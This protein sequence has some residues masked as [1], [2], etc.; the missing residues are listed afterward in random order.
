MGGEQ[1]ETKIGSGKGVPRVFVEL[2]DWQ[3]SGDSSFRVGPFLNRVHE[4]EGECQFLVGVPCV[5][6]V[7]FTLDLFFLQGNRASSEIF[8]TLQKKPLI[9]EIQSIVQ[10]L[11]LLPSSSHNNSCYV[12]SR[13]RKVPFLNL[14]IVPEALRGEPIRVQEC[15][16]GIFG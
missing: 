4:Y 11:N 1:G 5:Q 10:T 9:K 8:V 15:L 2:F 14:V 13:Q 6:Q 7:D 12:H 16:G 3:Y